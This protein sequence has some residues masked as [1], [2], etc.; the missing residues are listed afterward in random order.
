MRDL[1]TIRVGVAL[2]GDGGVSTGAIVLDHVVMG[3]DHDEI[4][5]FAPNSRDKFVIWEY[6]HST[7]RCA[8]GQYFSTLVN[9]MEQWR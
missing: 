2:E 4:L 8:R 1:T 9:A 5:C 3:D 7:G 6:T